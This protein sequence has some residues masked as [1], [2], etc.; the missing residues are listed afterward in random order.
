MRPI[1][2]KK[3]SKLPIN[4]KF[5]REKFY[6]ENESDSHL[7]NMLKIAIDY[8]EMQ[9]GLSITQKV[10]KVIHNNN[11]VVLPYGPVTK[12]VSVFDDKKKNVKI[13]KTERYR[14]SF[15]L[16]FSK[17]I[18]NVIISYEAGYNEE[19]LPD[20]LKN[21]ITEKFWELHCESSYNSF[22][23]CLDKQEKNASKDALWHF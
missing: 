17:D 8:V 9:T 12:I 21:S 20:C 18:K 13:L 3:S 2:E 22:D 1:L 16:H 10:W 6:L 5:L 19:N 11:Y 7:N 23:S 15:I 14:E 4:L